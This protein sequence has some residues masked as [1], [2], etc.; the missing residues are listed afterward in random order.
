MR[1]NKSER[2]SI[3]GMITTRLSYL[4][5]ILVLAALGIFGRWVADAERKASQQGRPT[6]SLSL[7]TT[8]SMGVGRAV[9]L[10]ALWQRAREARRLGAWE[11]QD[12]LLRL[13]EELSPNSVMVSVHRAQLFAGIFALQQDKREAAER[14]LKRAFS[15]LDE[16]LE[17]HPQS[18]KPWETAC[19]IVQQSGTH[20]P[21]LTAPLAADLLASHPLPGA[22]GA[23]YR[24]PLGAE[25]K[26]LQAQA[27]ASPGALELF[28]QADPAAHYSE[29]PAFLRLPR[30]AQSIVAN[31]SVLLA[32]SMEILGLRGLEA[33]LHRESLLADYALYGVA[34]RLKSLMV[35]DPRYHQQIALGMRAIRLEA[36]RLLS[37]GGQRRALGFLSRCLAAHGDWLDHAAL[38]DLADELRGGELMDQ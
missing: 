18:S 27:E 33:P 2:S 23:L 8:Q 34:S 28:S 15:V 9:P 1:V 5:P 16:A 21:Y 31:A 13:I 29:H 6:S 12:K 24:L 14:W 25:F 30:G 7:V 32:E 11:E 17:R 36:S 19:W 37:V 4:V 10:I 3:A 38:A 22:K 20:Y 35:T 26:E